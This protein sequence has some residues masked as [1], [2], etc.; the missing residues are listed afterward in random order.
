MPSRTRRQAPSRCID[1]LE[2]PR[3]GFHGRRDADNGPHRGRC[4]RYNTARKVLWYRS[5]SRLLGGGVRVTGTRGR[6]YRCPSSQ[7]CRPEP[8]SHGAA[9]ARGSHAHNREVAQSR[10]V[11]RVAACNG[12]PRRTA[13]PLPN[14]GDHA[15]SSNCG[16]SR[17]PLW[18]CRCGAMR[19]RLPAGP[20]C[21]G[22]VDLDCAGASG[23][24]GGDRQDLDRRPVRVGSSDWLRLGR[25]RGSQVR[26][27]RNHRRRRDITWAISALMLV[28]GVLASIH[29]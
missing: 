25:T 6:G 9:R 28:V 29:R 14:A 20:R 19:V 24:E 27:P 15:R 2:D 10:A 8:G 4:L 11:D 21:P 17:T 16:W 13:R 7:P 1:D 12:S 23:G 3:A 5:G 22:K 18:R 26:P